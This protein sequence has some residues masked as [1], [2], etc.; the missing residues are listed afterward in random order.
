[1]FPQDTDSPWQRLYPDKQTQ[2]GTL[3]NYFVQ[4]SSTTRVRTGSS[5]QD[6]GTDTR[7]QQDTL[8][9][10]PL[11]RSRIR[12]GCIRSEY[13]GQSLGR[14]TQGGTPCSWPLLRSQMF[15]P[16]TAPAVTMDQDTRIQQGMFRTLS[17]QVSRQRFRQGMQ[18][19]AMKRTSTQIPARMPCNCSKIPQRV[20]NTPKDMVAEP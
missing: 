12:R 7:T 3:C 19:A 15:R 18:Q 11:D 13:L 17:R 9:S 20:S 6:R 1:M 2:Q 10:S 14:H 8:C 4:P 5:D 16:D